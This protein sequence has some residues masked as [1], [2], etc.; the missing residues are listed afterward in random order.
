[1]LTTIHRKTKGR[2]GFTLI[3]LMIV[4]SIIGILFTIAVPSYKRSVIKARETALA[5]N[6]YQMRQAIDAYF[7]DNARYPDSLEALVDA[8]Y[9]RSIPRD[10]F[11]HETD[12]WETVP[13]EPLE[14]GELAEGG[15][16][17][18]HSGSDLVGLNGVPYQEW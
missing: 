6:L 5:E 16:F 1:M 7:A 13:P 18:V 4:M 3:E 9:L 2:R 17:D 11:T 15:V 10:P 14:S 8:R 12:S